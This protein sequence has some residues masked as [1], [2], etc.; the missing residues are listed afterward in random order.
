MLSDE[1]SRTV[2]SGWVGV[3]LL[4][5]S[6][7][8]T[9][10]VLFADTFSGQTPLD[11]VAYQRW[12]NGILEGI[13][14]AA[15]TAFVYPPGG[16][17]IF[18]MTEVISG[19]G[20][21]RT[22]TLLAL[23]SDFAILVAL[24]RFGTA[25]AAVAQFPVGPWVW[26][27]MGFVAGPLMYQRFDV[28]AA[29]MAVLA[30]LLAARPALSGAFAGL[31]FLVKL[32]PEIA[33]LALPRHRLMRGLIANLITVVVGWLILHVWMG[34]SLGFLSN[35]VNKGLSVEAVAAYPFLVSRALFSSHGVT[36]QYGSWEVIGP[37]VP[38]AATISTVVGVV[39]LLGLFVARLL[40]RL[41]KAAPGDIVL[42][43]VLIFVAT[44]K[45]NSLQY[46]IW[47][48]AMTA[49]ALAFSSSRA[50][51]PAVLLTLM[52]IVADQV[53]WTYFVD[54]ISG[55][56]LFLVFQGLRL[57]LLLAATIWLAL[58]IFRRGS[59]EPRGSRL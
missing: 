3:A 49:T 12:A 30:V 6:W 8:V 31:G 34:D 33:L 28:F 17:V 47:I 20:F 9:R 15:D 48:A 25:K 54:F 53:I 56:P 22:F 23:L 10:A 58:E 50:R 40:G 46:G 41:E 37:G 4:V 45:I 21:F 55:N 57:L 7:L 26:I 38:L 27:L 11:V 5:T 51:G 44:H 1:R 39:L 36:G 43:G 2:G 59:P 35:V 14:P 24:L 18:L 42:L 32:W 19:E 29:L 52:L 16:N 13:S